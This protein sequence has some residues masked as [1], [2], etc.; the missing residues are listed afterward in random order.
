MARHDEI[1]AY[2]TKTHLPALLRKVQTGER[3]TITQRGRP[4]AE[5]VPCGSAAR[6]DGAAAARKMRGFMSRHPVIAGV[7]IKALIEE[8]RD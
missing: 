7:D 2:E 1:G 8:G 5:L 6:R 3:F 4:V